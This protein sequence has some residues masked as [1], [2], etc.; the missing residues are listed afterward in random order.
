MSD[1]FVIPNKQGTLPDSLDLSPHR[2]ISLFQSQSGT[3]SVFSA[4]R[5][6]QEVQLCMVD[7]AGRWNVENI[8]YEDMDGS[9]VLSADEQAWLIACWASVLSK[10][11]F[12]VAN[13]Y[14]EARLSRTLSVNIGIPAAVHDQLF[15]ST[16]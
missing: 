11:I 14:L 13:K 8:K 3:Q 7:D 16:T 10:P 2:I 6:S 4:D 5:K 9:F 1:P 15:R 12:E